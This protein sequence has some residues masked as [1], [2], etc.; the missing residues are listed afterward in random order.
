M[1]SNF[2]RN[3]RCDAHPAKSLAAVPVNTN[4]PAPMIVA[5]PIIKASPQPSTRSRELLGTVVS[6]AT[7]CTSPVPGRACEA[8]GAPSPGSPGPAGGKAMPV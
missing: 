4:T 7:A 5:M 2:D 8:A 3:P 6:G 1:G